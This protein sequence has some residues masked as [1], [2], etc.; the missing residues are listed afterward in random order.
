[1]LAAGYA[2]QASP[3]GESMG[4]LLIDGALLFP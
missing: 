3:T 1:M 2:R 4:R